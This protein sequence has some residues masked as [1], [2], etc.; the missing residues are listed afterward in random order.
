MAAVVGIVSGRDSKTFQNWYEKM[1]EG[2]L[3]QNLAR[4]LFSDRT[5]LQATT[6]VS[7]TEVLMNEKLQSVLELINCD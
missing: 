2:W 7:S 4:F 6:A 3:N 5:T 1:I